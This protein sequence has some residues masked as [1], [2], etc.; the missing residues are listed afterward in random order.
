[1]VEPK[2]CKKAQGEAA[3][4]T[5]VEAPVEASLDGAPLGGV[6]ILIV[7][8]D[9]YRDIADTLRAGATRALKAAGCVF[10]VITVPGAL[11]IP[12]A[13]LLALQAARGRAGYHG[14]VA[15]GC[16]IRGET[17][18]YDVVAG[19]SA[20]ALMDIALMDRGTVRGI[21][22]GNGILTV[23]NAAQAEK[24]AALDDG[25]K[26]GTAAAAVLALVRLKRRLRASGNQGRRRR[27]PSKLRPGFPLTPRVREGE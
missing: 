19:E 4:E 5:P 7:E 2:R 9:Y 3:V 6:R 17:S 15:L 13:I 16:V 11:E 27:T 21:A 26:G 23:D 20:R 8:S 12:Q 25:D 1:M 22:V 24:R 14:V 10:D 18:H